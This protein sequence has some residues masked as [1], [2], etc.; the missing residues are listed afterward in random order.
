MQHWLG[1]IK[2]DDLPGDRGEGEASV[3]AAGGNVED[4]RRVARLSPGEKPLQVRAL[5]VNAASHLGF[6]VT[7]ELRPH[8]LLPGAR[9]PLLSVLGELTEEEIGIAGREIKPPRGLVHE[10]HA[11]RAGVF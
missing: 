3:A 9:S 2:R 1:H 10:L 5:G 7:A 4:A 11:V 8:A 6:P